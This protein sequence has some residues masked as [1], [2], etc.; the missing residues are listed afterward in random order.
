MITHG[1]KMSKL[2]AYLALNVTKASSPTSKKTTAIAR[3][4]E[5]GG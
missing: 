5:A 2:E 1:S 3:E 4:M